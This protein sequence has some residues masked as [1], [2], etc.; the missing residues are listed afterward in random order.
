MYLRFT[1][2]I[3]ISGACEILN[4]YNVRRISILKLDTT[5][6]VV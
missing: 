5:S 6:E 4:F 2:A 3:H 1:Q